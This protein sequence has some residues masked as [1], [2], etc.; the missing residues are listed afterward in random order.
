[1]TVGAG[2]T[3]EPYTNA[4]GTQSAD[5]PYGSCS[6]TTGYATVWY[7]FTAPASGAV[8]ISTANGSGTHTLTN[9]RLALFAA[10]DVNDYLTFS[11]IS[12]DED[13]GTGS[14][15]QM[16][17]LYATGLTAGNVYYIQVDAFNNANQ[18]GTFCLTVDELDASMLSATG[19][20]AAGQ[21]PVGSVATYT[22]W[23]S[24]V[25]TSSRL[26]AMVRNP[27]GGNVSA[28]SISQHINGGAVRSD[29]VSGEYYLDRNFSITNVEATNV[30]VR[31]FFLDSELAALQTADAAVALLNLAITRQ[32]GACQADF[33]AGNGTNS[34]LVQTGSGSAAGVSWVNFTTPG[35]SNFFI[36]SQRAELIVKA[37][38]QGAYLPSLGRHKNILAGWATNLNV[39]ALSQPYNIA[40]FGN[41]AG[42]ETVSNGFFAATADT[43]DIIDWVLVE[44][45]N[46]SNSLIA[47]R[48]A[49]IRED[50]YIV[51]L[52]GTSPVRLSGLATDSYHITIRHRNHLGIS[53]QNMTAIN[54]RA[55]GIASAPGLNFD[56]TSAPDADIFG[57]SSAY[58][59]AGGKNVM[60]GGNA[61]SNNNVKYG[62]PSNDP[63]SIL[64]YLGGNPIITMSN[65]YTPNDVNMDGSVKYG[66]PSNDPSFILATVLGG[67]PL[68]TITEQKR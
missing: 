35:F 30:E 51:D 33:D 2:C 1:V 39:N 26:I 59:I 4:G 54:A 60:V 49:F 31:L 37:Y 29:V 46:S 10:T 50:G 41:Y 5:E 11:I 21:T 40:A 65:V 28:Y 44:I 58:K 45:K 25:D 43:T 36:H 68:I 16:S 12:C 52:D 19:N 6:A 55:L 57:T 53:T 3:G 8:R 42:T 7:K 66:G 32:T 38:L 62:G 27:A 23:V 13:G 20:C 18:G 67:S 22:G 15:D 9:S 48:A 56:F 64:G 14:Y 34:E 47:R 63:A 17:V 61:N 24:L